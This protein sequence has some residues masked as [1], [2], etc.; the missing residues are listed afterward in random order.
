[1]VLRY[2]DP[3]RPLAHGRRYFHR[4]GRQRDG[5]DGDS[6]SGRLRPGTGPVQRDEIWRQDTADGDIGDVWHGDKTYVGQPYLVDEKTGEGH[7]RSDWIAISSY[8][9]QLNIRCQ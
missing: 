7:F 9:M 8:E 5:T 2:D 4:Q 1:M 6:G 3:D